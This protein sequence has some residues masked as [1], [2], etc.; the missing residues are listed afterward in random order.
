MGKGHRTLQIF[1]RAK[2]AVDVDTMWDSPVYRSLYPHSHHD[3]TK[4]CS[5]AKK[6]AGIR[7][8]DRFPILAKWLATLLASQWCTFKWK[9]NRH[10]RRDSTCNS[11][12]LLA[13]GFRNT[14]WNL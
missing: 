7:M 1:F 10:C 3:P 6:S 8:H 5:T 14:V 13:P 11:S 2:M 4:P 9:G 12:L